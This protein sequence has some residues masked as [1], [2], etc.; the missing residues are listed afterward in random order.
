VDSSVPSWEKWSKNL[1]NHLY[2]RRGGLRKIKGGA[3][4]GGRGSNVFEIF[5]NRFVKI[6]RVGQNISKNTIFAKFSNF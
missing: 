2:K 5:F 1:Q 3:G 4:W 6:L